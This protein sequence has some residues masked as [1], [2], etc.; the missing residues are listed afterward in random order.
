MGYEID[1][2]SGPIKEDGEEVEPEKIEDEEDGR[3]RYYLTIKLEGSQCY[4][5]FDTAFRH[6]EITYPLN[7]ANTVSR[8]LETDE[9]EE[10]T[11]E[12]VDWE[13]LD[14]LEESDLKRNAALKVID[15]TDPSTAHRASFNLSAYT[16]TALV[17]Y[18]HRLAENNFPIEFQCT[19]SM[20]PY[21][22]DVTLQYLDDRIMPV[23]IAGERGRRYAQ[24]SFAIEK[25]DRQPAEYEIESL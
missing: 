17:D 5:V 3:F 13:S 25:E 20:F 7:I 2:F 15:N 18:R 4:I 12:S 11:G 16:S 1:D 8:Q 24:Y 23:I 19:R 9:I 22:E 10:L 6:A 21:T 14:E